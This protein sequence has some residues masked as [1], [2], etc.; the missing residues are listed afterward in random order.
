MELARQGWN[1]FTQ[2]P[3][4]SGGGRDDVFGTCTSTPWILVTAIKDT[5][6]SLSYA[7]RE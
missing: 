4:S 2:S 7:L 6:S 1:D 5:L 3:G